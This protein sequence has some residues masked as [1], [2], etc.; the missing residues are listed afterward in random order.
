LKSD[1]QLSG[2]RA[3]ILDFGSKLQK[4]CNF[5]IVQ[6]H[7]FESEEG[8]D[9]PLIRPAG[10]GHPLPSG[11]VLFDISNQ[12]AT[13]GLLSVCTKDRV[14]NGTQNDVWRDKKNSDAIS[15]TAGQ[16]LS[17]RRRRKRRAAHDALSPTGN[18]EQAENTSQ[19]CERT[20]FISHEQPQG[21]VP[22]PGA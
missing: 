16:S 6:F 12:A 8:K 4:S 7:D 14:A 17:F 18:F 11:E 15:K 5:E 3:E 19:H 9:V 10:A 2:V 13:G 20:N 21:E 1:W 22:P